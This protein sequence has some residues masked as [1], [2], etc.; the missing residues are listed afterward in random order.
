MPL[1]LPQPLC[2]YLNE[3]SMLLCYYSMALCSM[4]MRGHATSWVLC[5]GMGS[6]R[7]HGSSWVLLACQQRGHGSSCVL[8]SC[9]NLCPFVSALRSPLYLHALSLSLYCHPSSP[10]LCMPSSLPHIISHLSRTLSSLSHKPLSHKISGLRASLS[11][12]I[13]VCGTSTF[14]EK[15]VVGIANE[16]LA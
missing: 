4:A 14:S 1:P 6:M 15:P 2:R 11:H 16:K 3:T 13:S 12:T 9:S 7:G 5:V 8:L 10:S